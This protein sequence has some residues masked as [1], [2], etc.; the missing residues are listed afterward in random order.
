[1]SYSS[2]WASILIFPLFQPSVTDSLSLNCSLFCWY[3]ADPRAFLHAEEFEASSCRG[4]SGFSFCVGVKVTGNVWFT[5]LSTKSELLGV[6]TEEGV[7]GLTS[8]ALPTDHSI[9]LLKK[10]PN[11]REYLGS[12]CPHH[13]LRVSSIP[14]HTACRVSTSGT[15]LSASVL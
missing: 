8:L 9:G 5:D 2:S 6:W 14:E 1:M 10:L 15:V 4:V 3:K 7:P 13:T 12:H 11:L